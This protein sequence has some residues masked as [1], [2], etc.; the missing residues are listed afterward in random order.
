IYPNNGVSNKVL[1]QS[2][3][4]IIRNQSEPKFSDKNEPIDIRN[5]TST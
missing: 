1:N 2:D 3:K 5:P 4:L